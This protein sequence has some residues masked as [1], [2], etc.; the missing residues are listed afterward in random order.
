MNLYPSPRLVDNRA[1]DYEQSMTALADV[2]AKM[3]ILGSR[4]WFGLGRGLVSPALATGRHFRPGPPLRAC[5]AP[6][7]YQSCC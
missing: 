4:D 6:Q 7:P 2:I 5:F 3:K 1:A